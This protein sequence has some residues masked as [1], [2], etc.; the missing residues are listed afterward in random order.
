MSPIMFFLII[1]CT[2]DIS[3][4]A[5]VVPDIVHQ[6]Y[7]YRQPNFFMYLS[8]ICVQ[9]YMKPKRH[10]LWVNDEGRYN[11]GFWEGWKKKAAPGS[12][13]ADLAKLID[14]GKIEAKFLSYPI[15]PPGNETTFV[16]NKAHRSDFVRMNA[17]KSMGGIYLDTDAF[18]IASLDQLRQHNFTISF[19]NIVNADSKAPKRLNNGVLL[20]SPDAPFLRVWMK[21][22]RT[23]D[24]SSFEYHSSTL[25]YHLAT[26]YP[27]LLHIEMSRISPISF[28]F[29]TSAAAAA[30]ACGIYSPAG[31][32]IWSPLWDPQKK[33]FTYSGTQPDY[34]LYA[35]LHNKL[36]LHLTM[37][38]VRGLC[39][40]RKTLSSPSD[41]AKLPSMLGSVFRL[42][43]RGIEKDETANKISSTGYDSFDYNALVNADDASK[44][45]AWTQC[46]GLL[47][48]HTPPDTKSTD[49]QQYVAEGMPA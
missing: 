14:S 23:F 49:R 25:P 31:R 21:A 4:A 20:S 44:E 29:Q 34:N 43:L 13:E 15:H 27:D 17:L 6:T 45:A 33:K 35:A 22:Y 36:V 11:K 40:M 16:S 10:I 7:D 41:L 2:L 26:Q 19:D 24:P 47:G 8:F 32:F 1:F 12:W 48:M 37:S 30:L 5:L 39:M 42:A 38:Q 28:A 9:H 18:P 46:R 3:S